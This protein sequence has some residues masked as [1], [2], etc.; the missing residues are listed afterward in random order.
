[1]LILSG[2]VK[3]TEKEIAMD[4]EIKE[5]IDKMSLKE[6]IGQLNQVSFRSESIDE[7]AK[8]AREGSI[9]AFVM[10]STAF[11]GDGTQ[12]S[13]RTCDMDAVQQSCVGGGKIPVMYG[14]DVIH[15]HKVVFPIPLAMAASFDPELVKESYNAIAAEAYSD[16]VRWTFAPMI[17]VSRDPRWGR[18]IE[19]PGEDPYLGSA[20]AEAVTRGFQEGEYKIAACAKHYIGYGASEGGRDYHKC[21]ISDYTLRNY[22]LRPFKA[23]VDA[24]IDT[25]MTSF[26]EISG[27]PT[28]SSKYLM[29]DVLRGELNFKGF[30]VSDWN[31]VMQL[32][33]QGVAGS[34]KEAAEL[35]VNAGVDM[36]MVSGCYA[37]FL[38]E[39]VCEGKVDAGRI[40]EAVYRILSIKKK[41]GILDAPYTESIS[42]NIEEHIEKAVKMA[43]GSMVLLKNDDDLLPIAREKK[44]CLIG[45]MVNEKRSLLGSWTLDGDLSLVRSFHEAFAD[46]ISEENILTGSMPDEA[47]MRIR[48]CDVVIACLGESYYVSGEGRDL[49]MIELPKWQTELIKKAYAAGKSI[50]GLMCFGRPV[51]MWEIEPYLKAVLYTWHCGTGTAEAAVKLIYGEES[52]SGRLP[53]TMPRCTGQI[54]IYYNAPSSGRP[55]NGYYGEEE[56]PFMYNYTDYPGTPMYPFGY[57]LTYT[58][59]AYSKPVCDKTALSKEELLGGECFEISV[60]VENTGSNDA[61]EVVQLYV[62]DVKASMTRPLRELKGFSKENIA[63]GASRTVSFRL[64]FNELGFYNE[65]GRFDVE[66]GEFEIYTGGDCTAADMVKIYVR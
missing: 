54:P 6:K 63:T 52:P 64:G 16:G 44:I 26:N 37:D 59:F 3:I 22:Y 41:Y 55:V 39:L 50:I 27:Q 10:S 34:R 5:M 31:A 13:I 20:M 51:A 42:L 49:A 36:D 24:G 47:L 15:G 7:A 45:P 30:V 19:S 23:A 40:D 38:E 18:C 43:L 29:T 33:K 53:M 32:E 8:A 14:R 57:G 62:R 65:D 28:N 58:K 21:E 9:G 17:D 25:V 60:R 1:M 61:S 56:L 46:C 12:R 4:T 66:P 2:Y 35:A 48:E 11:A